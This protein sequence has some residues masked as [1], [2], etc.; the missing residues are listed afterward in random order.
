MSGNSGQNLILM[1]DYNISMVEAKHC[2][3]IAKGNLT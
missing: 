1:T 2:C 3:S